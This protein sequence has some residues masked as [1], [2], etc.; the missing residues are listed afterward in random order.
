M[1]ESTSNGDALASF[2]VPFLS[3]GKA[4]GK[5]RCGNVV[6]LFINHIRLGSWLCASSTLAK[7]AIDDPKTCQD[8]L[9]T[10]IHHPETLEW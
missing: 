7:L 9:D 10:V 6:Q 5:L 2:P 4:Y 8:L 3:G 1:N